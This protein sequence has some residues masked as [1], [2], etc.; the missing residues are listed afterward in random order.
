MDDVTSTQAAADKAADK[1]TDARA[2]ADKASDVADVAA[3]K[4]DDKPG[5]KPLAKAADAADA[6]AEKAGDKATALEVK[7]A[8]AAGRVA[9]P[10]K[11]PIVAEVEPTSAERAFDREHYPAEED[12]PIL[13]KVDEPEV[14]HDLKLWRLSARDKNEP[15]FHYGDPRIAHDYMVVAHSAKEARHF[16]HGHLGNRVSFTEGK[17]VWLDEDKTDCVPFEMTTAGVVGTSI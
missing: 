8:D 12:P 14:D 6:A 3:A 4:A 17:D 7:A 13:P 10:E 16:A 15:P 2:V 9:A 11:S 5:S 1:A